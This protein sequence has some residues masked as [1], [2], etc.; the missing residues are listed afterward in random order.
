MFWASF[1]LICTRCLRKPRVIIDISV[2]FSILDELELCKAGN[3]IAME[4][5]SSHDLFFP[6]FFQTEALYLVKRKYCISSL[7]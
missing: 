2:Q 6:S 7:G 1:F 5:D 4:S 3:M